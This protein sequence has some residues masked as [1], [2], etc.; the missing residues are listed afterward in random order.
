MR[1]LVVSDVHGD[2][3]SLKKAID[4]QPSAEVVIFCGDGEKEFQTIKMYYSNKMF[5]GVKGNCDFGSMLLG[6][7]TITLEGKKIFITH[8]HLYNAK[9]TMTNLY[10]AAKE[11]N[12][13]ILLYGH[14]H[15]AVSDYNDGMYILNPG[16]CNGYDAS[17]AYIDITPS[18]IMTN[19]LKIR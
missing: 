8:G 9:M 18:G 15:K 17:Y 3:Y 16:S 19:I 13:D 5:I 11:Q 1:I 10:Y 14:T 2:F 12:A 6:V 4:S 7:E